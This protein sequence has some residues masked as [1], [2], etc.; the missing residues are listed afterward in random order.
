MWK[1]GSCGERHEETFDACWR[2]GTTRA[3][4]AP[5][6][7]F[8]VPDDAPED[9]PRAK[10]GTCVR[11][12]SQSVFPATQI[13]D[14]DDGIKRSLTVAVDGD[15][16]AWVFKDR[17]TGT[18]KAWICGTCGHTELVCDGAAELLQRYLER[19]S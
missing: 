16:G 5:A 4:E 9:G 18:L 11:C 2:C 13:I 15:P 8:E 19:E 10:L 17:V 14:H 6:G 3:G 7:A 1:C 12:G